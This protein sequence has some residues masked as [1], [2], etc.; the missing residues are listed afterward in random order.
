MAMNQWELRFANFCAVAG[1]LMLF[2][3]GSLY[4]IE[5]QMTQGVSYSFLAGIALLI[6]YGILHPSAVIDLIRSR[7]ARF[8]SLSIVVTALVLGVLVMANV[9]AARGTQALDLTHGGLNTLAPQSVLAA[10][11]LTVDLQV[12]GLF[13]AGANNGQREAETLIDLYAA[14]SPHVKYRTENVD[15]AIQDVRL[16]GVKIAD[17]IVLDYRGKTELLTPGAQSEQDITSA[18]IKLESD[19][20]PVVCWAVGDGERDLKENNQSYGYTGVADLLSRNNFAAHDLLLSQAVTIPADCDVIAVVGPSHPLTEASIKSLADYLAASGKLLLAVEPWQ[21]AKVTESAN[22]IVKPFGLT[23]A[24]GLVIEPDTSRAASGDPTTPAIISFGASP[25]SKDLAGTYAFFPQTTAITGTA[26]P[27]VS[28]VPIGETSSTSYGIASVRRDLARTN[29]D[30]GG[31][32]VIMETIEKPS[33]AK[34][35]RIA[36]AGTGSFAENATLPPNASGANLQLALATFQWLT[37]QDSLISIPPKASRNL[38][39]TLTQQ[40]QSLLIFTTGLLLPS[41]IAF[42]GLGVWWRRR[43]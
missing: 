16:Y 33:V 5:Q 12:V 40:Q 21:D 15:T 32:F 14:Q 22:A 36:L 18:L 39:L 20:V 31:P 6:A 10:Q 7:R 2:L 27:A 1:V 24:G 42:G 43:A 34:K 23:F 29:A 38:P 8:G 3:A 25:I 13:R 26:V 30:K 35:M 4:G 17:T 28:A 19:H 11:R 41:L 37:E 9:L